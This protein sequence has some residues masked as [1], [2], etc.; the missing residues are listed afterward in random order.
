MKKV[1]LIPIMLILTACNVKPSESVEPSDSFAGPTESVENEQPTEGVPE[2]ATADVSPDPGE[3]DHVTITFADYE[4]RQSEWQPIID[5]FNLENPGITVVFVPLVQDYIEGI[6]SSDTPKRAMSA[7]TS[8]VFAITPEAAPYLLDLQL[9][10]DEDSNFPANDFWPAAR[11]ACLD[12]FGRPMGLPLELSA[13]A[14]FYD[15][16]VFDRAG[17]AAPQPGWT[18]EDFKL[19]VDSLSELP[20]IG[21]SF[22][23]G[24]F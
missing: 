13:N 6:Q 20:E 10:M 15:K 17:L 8:V 18:W 22:A 9:L 5:Q 24:P 16:D 7:D 4:Y 12:P 14:I 11:Q 2:G 21:Y 23:D 1:L 3:D 19:A